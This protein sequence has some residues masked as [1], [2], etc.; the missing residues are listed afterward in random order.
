[1]SASS[2]RGARVWPLCAVIV[3]SGDVCTRTEYHD[4]DEQAPFRGPEPRAGGELCIAREAAGG[5]RHAHLLHQ[6]DA[7]FP[8]SADPGAYPRLFVR[9]PR[10]AHGAAL[11][12]EVDFLG[13]AKQSVGVPDSH[14]D[15]LKKDSGEAEEPE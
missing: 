13:V 5:H 9:G 4:H 14:P 3:M 10:P 15:H 2:R 1:M 12:S 8:G 6:L 7:P 11:L